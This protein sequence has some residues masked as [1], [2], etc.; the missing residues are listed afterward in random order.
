MVFLN[1]SLLGLIQKCCKHFYN[2]R[3]DDVEKMLAHECDTY[4]RFKKITFY[5]CNKTRRPYIVDGEK[6][7][8]HLCAMH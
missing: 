7:S 8:M 6:G 4:S 2:S 1:E 5:T 3:L